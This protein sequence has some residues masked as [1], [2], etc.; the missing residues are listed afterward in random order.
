M[1][2]ETLM[3]IQQMV[4]DKMQGVDQVEKEK[5]ARHNQIAKLSRD[6]KK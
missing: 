2:P 1:D 5:K 4:M 3:L 6:K